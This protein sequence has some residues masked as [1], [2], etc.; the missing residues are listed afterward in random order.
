[1]RTRE[2]KR[3]QEGT[4]IG[5]RIEV[6]VRGTCSAHRPGTLSFLSSASIRRIRVPPRSIPRFR[7]GGWPMLGRVTTGGQTG[8][9]QAGW[10]AAKRFG[11][12]TGGWMPLGFRTEGPPDAEGEP[13][14]DEEHPEFGELYGAR[15]H[16]SLEYRVRT[17]EN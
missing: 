9:D 3:V 1:M 13:G 16:E 7:K 8:A 10:R 5:S 4:R 14:A 15:A 12:A 11:M 17:R 6:R 2:G